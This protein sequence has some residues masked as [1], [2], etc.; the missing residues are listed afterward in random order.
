MAVQLDGDAS[1]GELLRVRNRLVPEDVQVAD[2][3]VGGSEADEIRQ[4][5]WC[6]YR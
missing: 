1:S 6:R 2:L 3:D 5:S 4:P